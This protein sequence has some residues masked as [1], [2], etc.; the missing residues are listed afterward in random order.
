MKSASIYVL[1]ILVMLI[2]CKVLWV[3]GDLVLKTQMV[4]DFPTYLAPCSCLFLW[5]G[6]K[7]QA[8]QAGSYIV[9]GVAM[10][11][12]CIQICLPVPRP[13][14]AWPWFRAFTPIAQT[15]IGWLPRFLSASQR[16]CLVQNE[17][18]FCLSHSQDVYFAQLKTLE[19]IC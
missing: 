6:W 17:L 18:V 4:P 2:W 1:E 3:S 14:G 7:S 15:S 11:N 16:F 8:L 13:A 9:R 5:N 19:I 12:F 10:H